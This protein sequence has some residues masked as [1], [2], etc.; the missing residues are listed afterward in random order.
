MGFGLDLSGCAASGTTEDLIYVSPKSGR[1]VSR[2]A[3]EPFKDKLF[4]L[5]AFLRG[6]S[7]VKVREK[8]V[9]N[10]LLLTGYFLQKCAFQPR[11]RNL[12]ESRARLA[13]KFDV[14]A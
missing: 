2:K 7:S 4:K 14:D 10:G 13:A 5:P 12:P 9:R 3:G 6:D 8:D 1:A 11:Q